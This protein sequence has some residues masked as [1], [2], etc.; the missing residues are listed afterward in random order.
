MVVQNII[1]VDAVFISQD[2]LGKE[3]KSFSGWLINNKPSLHIGKTECILFVL[4]GNLKTITDIQ[5]NCNCHIIKS[6][7]NIK[8]LGIDIDKNL[9]SERTTNV[10][11][12]LVNSLL[13]FMY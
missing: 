4:K 9:S 10:I 2:W 3:L 8:Y 6:Q 5:L 7:S 11:I 12:K 13:R 1:S